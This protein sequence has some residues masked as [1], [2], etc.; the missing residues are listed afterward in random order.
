MWWRSHSV[1]QHDLQGNVLCGYGNDFAYACYFFVTV[2]N[3][4]AARRWLGKLAHEV[5]NAVP[6]GGD[7]KPL[8]TLNVALTY[9]GLEHVGVP[10]P[11]LATFPKEFKE[12][13]GAPERAEFLGDVGESDPKEWHEGLK[14]GQPDILVTITA[15]DP[16]V[17][18]R[19]VEALRHDFDELQPKL[20]VEHP[21]GLLDDGHKDLSH[22]REHFGFADGFSQPAIRGNAGPDTRKGMGTPG[23]W[24]WREVAPGEFVL[25]YRGEDGLLPAAPEEPLGR[26]GSFMVVR[27]LRQ[28]VGRFAAYMKEMVEKSYVKE[29]A[30]LDLGEAGTGNLRDREHWL[31]AKIVGRWRD[32]G[33]LVLSSRPLLPRG[34]V[35]ETYSERINRFRYRG[36]DPDGSRCPLGAHVRRANP[37]DG[38]GWQGRLTKRHRIIRRGMPYGTRAFDPELAPDERGGLFDVAESE[39][40]G[41]RQQ[42]RGLMFVCFQASIA[43]Q[44]EVIQGRWLNDGDAFWLGNERD[45]LTISA[46][47][48]S[49]GPV[50]GSEHAVG[51]R[52]A[53]DRMT[54][55]G[56]P[57]RFLA[58]QPSF[59]TTR[60]GGYFFVPGLTAL[61]A[62]ASAYWR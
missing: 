58:P 14:P 27:K 46:N 51:S 52:I 28:H 8:S 44:F 38:L 55:Q 60:G 49:P 22:A 53:S 41:E 34:T 17:L 45:F 15:R 62:L 10:A 6:W 16:K 30:G 36:S 25:G 59:V 48:D 23:R 33:S 21:A 11:I 31:A 43:R 12:G 20:V 61:R 37:R 50:G 54:I 42:E 4:R 35:D 18:A 39:E 19:R 56:E 24:R 5:T 57:P 29:A 40:Q 2:D 26:S 7:F 32:G 47:G 1:D 9:Q 13:M 3:E